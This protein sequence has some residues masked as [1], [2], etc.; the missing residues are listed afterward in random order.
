[1]SLAW[2]KFLKGTLGSS[3]LRLCLRLSKAMEPSLLST[4]VHTNTN[5]HDVVNAFRSAKSQNGRGYTYDTNLA[6][7]RIALA[8]FRYS[9]IPTFG[10]STLCGQ[11][12]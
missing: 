6:G 10:T 9:S 2:D 1:M 7:M 5:H 8:C 3:S 11:Q 4:D 12:L